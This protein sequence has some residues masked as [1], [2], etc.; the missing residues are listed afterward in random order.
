[1]PLPVILLMKNRNK[2]L[3]YNWLTIPKWSNI[4]LGVIYTEG[5][6]KILSIIE[7]IN[8]TDCRC[9]TLRECFE[10]KSEYRST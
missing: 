3:G 7:K 1:M 5:V 2:E 10:R 6:N 4:I 8:G 9:R